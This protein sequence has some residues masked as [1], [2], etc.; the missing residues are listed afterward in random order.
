M[1]PQSLNY[2]RLFSSAKHNK[3][4]INKVITCVLVLKFLAQHQINITIQD[5]AGSVY[6]ADLPIISNISPDK[7]IQHLF[8]G[9]FKIS[10]AGQNQ[11]VSA[12]KMY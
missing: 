1:D 3:Q 10:F 6:S 4:E 9:K 7:D 5:F 11:F 2:D 8:P 12:I